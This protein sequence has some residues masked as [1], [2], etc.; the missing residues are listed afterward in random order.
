MKKMFFLTILGLVSNICFA[1]TKQELDSLHKIV[2][3]SGQ[4][5][6]KVMALGLLGFYE[7]DLPKSLQLI[8]EAL[9]LTR[10]IK[11]E[12]G[13]AFCFHQ[14]GTYFG[15][16]VDNPK[17]LEYYLKALKI[18]EQ[19]QDREGI[20][21]SKAGIAFIYIRFGNYEAALAYLL[22]S[23]EELK[24]LNVP[25]RFVII[26]LRIAD[27]YFDQKKLD[28]ALIYF[29]K[30]NQY[31]M[32]TTGS[33]NLL[34]FSLAG[35]GKVYAEMGNTD[36]AFSYYKMSLANAIE[37]NYNSSISN[38][39]LLF[40][41]LFAKTGLIDSAMY[42]AKRALSV[43]QDKELKGHT[44]RAAKQLA[45][46]YENRD[47]K[48]AL[49]YYKMAMDA[50]DSIFSASNIAQI[51]NMTF[52]E[53]ERQ[54]EINEDKVKEADE[55]KHNLQFAAL[56]IVLITFVTV[57]LLLSRS[58]IVKTKFIEFFG[59]FGL[60]AVFEFINLFI[61]PYLAHATNDSPVLMLL[62]LIAIGA[63]LVPM[64]HKLEKWMTS[65]MVEKNKKVRLA[66]AKKT[67]ATL[68]EKQN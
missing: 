50:N 57:F 55:R 9:A 18:R 48:D 26:Y 19:I 10:K 43:S 20:A 38:T 5:T 65:V 54:R 66:A 60:L 12:K 6:A 21:M 40:S 42:Y 51:Q 32:A 4:D 17:S 58:I 27:V 2:A 56:A 15:R 23:E 33:K 36:L 52:S 63:L 62:I 46:L 61:H 47:D 59:V 11:F 13:E 39:C 31:A 64:H 49:R 24:Q 7:V 68:E 35:M 30:S 53:Q 14:L 41:K 16:I 28:S 44:V 37:N 67:I 8:N 3:T 22:K 34:S 29:Q 45:E 25:H 1:Q